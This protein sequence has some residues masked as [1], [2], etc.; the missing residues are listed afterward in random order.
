MHGVSEIPMNFGGGINWQNLEFFWLPLVLGGAGGLAALALHRW[1]RAT[2]ARLADS[3]LRALLTGQA[4]ESRRVLASVFFAFALVLLGV[5]LLRPQWGMEESKWHKKGIDL[6]VAVDLSASMLAADVEPNRLQASVLE[7]EEIMKRMRGGRLALIPFAGIAFKQ[8]PLTSDFGAISA[9]LQG[10]RPGDVPVPGTALGKALDEALDTLGIGREEAD[11]NGVVTPFK[12]SRFKVVLLITDGEDHGGDALAIAQKAADAGVRLYTVGVGSAAGDMVPDINQETGQPGQGRMTDQ[13]SGDPVVSH[14]NDQLLQDLARITGG[15]YFHY[16][17]QP[18]AGAVYAELDRLEKKEIEAT[19]ARLRQDR[20][21][22]LLVPAFILLLLALLLPELR[23]T[24]TP[25]PPVRTPTAREGVPVRT[26][27]ARE[28]VPVRT[29]TAREGVPRPSPAARAASG[30]STALLGLLLLLGL[31]TSACDAFKMNNRAVEKAR[32]TLEEGKAPEAAEALKALVPELPPAGELHYNL[33][34]AQLAAGQFDDAEKSLGSALELAPS[35]LEGKIQANLG[36]TLL[37]KAQSLPE[38]NP[39]REVALRKSVGALRKAVM[40]EPTAPEAARNLELALLLLEPP[41]EQRQD[42]FEPNNSLQAAVSFEEKIQETPLMLC[43]DDSDVF[44]VGVPAGAR[45]LVELGV[46]PEPK[47]EEEAAPPAPPQAPPGN[48]PPQG[49]GAPAGAEP[50]KKPEEG[51]AP[52]KGPAP[53]GVTMR[54][55]RGEEAE[56]EEAKKGRIF[57]KNEGQ[58]ALWFVSVTTTDD[59]EHPYG[60]GMY[61]LPECAKL[62]DQNNAN[63]SAQEAT[64]LDLEK[65]AQFQLC[66]GDDDWYWVDSTAGQ[67][68][69]VSLTMKNLQGMPSLRVTNEAGQTLAEGKLGKAPEGLVTLE[70]FLPDLKGGRLLFQVSG[71]DEAEGPGQLKA[72]LLPPCPEGDDEAEDNDTAETAKP[73]DQETAKLRLRYCPGDPDWYSLEVKDGQK[74]SVSLSTLPEG[75]KLTLKAYQGGDFTKTVAE[76]KASLKLEGKGGDQT[77]QV[78]L[79]G[80]AGQGLFYRLSLSGDEGEDEQDQEQQEQQQQEQQQQEQQE[81]QEQQAQGAE[82]MEAQIQELDERDR[83]NL[84]AQKAL[85][86]TPGA[87]APSGKPW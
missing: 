20:F 17:G 71:K 11:A 49:A 59:A 57:V 25:R 33:G 24:N 74:V 16:T 27:T 67:T 77:Y 6:A 43:P 75:K 87:R 73:L 79:E 38:D 54:L 15:K 10:L 55:Y 29:P 28:G 2:A 60:L 65:G 40:L 37:Q 84:E 36:L 81:Q 82:A 51:P 23:R 80:D 47:K 44:R 64:A 9:Y 78:T 19:M 62:E 68:L 1:R 58:D 66:P 32:A 48:Q 34:S 35:T 12:G 22:F 76:G 8:S 41:C 46:P 69:A 56:A 13:E 53:A 70:A 7:I 31:G 72:E 45:L 21:Q 52:I 3:P 14:L 42:P 61:V 30:S 86:L 26:P 85:R 83:E 39:E 5:A 18:I 50:E 63:N 4:A